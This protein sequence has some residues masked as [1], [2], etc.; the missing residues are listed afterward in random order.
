MRGKSKA[1]KKDVIFKQDTEKTADWAVLLAKTITGNN[2]EE[3]LLKNNLYKMKKTVL[4][5]RT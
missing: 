5:V 2:V 4:I 3:Y 1:N